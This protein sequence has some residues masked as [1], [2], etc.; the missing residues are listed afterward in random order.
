MT[1]TEKFDY[2]VRHLSLDTLVPFLLTLDKKE[3][4]EVRLKT[5]QLYKELNTLGW[6]EAQKLRHR[7]PHL[8]LAGL[9]TYTKQEAMA[10]S[11]DFPPG[12]LHGSVNGNQ[13]SPQALFEDVVTHFRPS[14]LTDW[15]VRNARANLWQTVDYQLLRQLNETGLVAY[16]PW[17]FGQVLANRLNRFNRAHKERN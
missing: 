7:V 11:F 10:R 8:F 16:D 2:H 17:L 4:V 6:S 1:V 5:K 14:W 9:A 3:L 13:K 12:F 15:L